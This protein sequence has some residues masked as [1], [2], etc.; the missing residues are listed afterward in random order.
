M[1]RHILLARSLSAPGSPLLNLSR[2]FSLVPARAK[3][4]SKHTHTPVDSAV[5]SLTFPRSSCR[6]LCVCMEEGGG[7]KGVDERWLFLRNH[8]P[9]PTRLGQTSPDVNVFQSLGMECRLKI[10]VAPNSETLHRRLGLPNSMTTTVLLRILE[11]KAALEVLTLPYWTVRRSAAHPGAAENH[12][13]LSALVL[14][15]E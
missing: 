10:C 3:I 13:V 9:H 14:M 15:S 7:G 5:P 4:P 11:L 12:G 8:S 6:V 2:M 1:T